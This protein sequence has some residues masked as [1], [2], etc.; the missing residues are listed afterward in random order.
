MKVVCARLSDITVI[1]LGALVSARL[2]FGESVPEPLLHA[3]FSALIMAIAVA[4]FPLFGI[5]R[6]WR[7]RAHVLLF[8]RVSLAWL[9]VQMI[10]AT[11][12]IALR[13]IHSLSL[14]WLSSWTCFTGLGLLGVRGVVYVVLARIRSAGAD[15]R[16]VAVVGSSPY[17]DQVLRDL[18]LHTSLGFRVVKVIELHGVDRP[19]S[20]RAERR[21]SRELEHLHAMAEAAELR[22]VWLALPLTA[23]EA[24]QRCVHTLRG[25]VVDLR[26]LPDVASLGIG[27]T[28]GVLDLM[29]RPAISLSPSSIPRDVINGKEVFDRLFAAAALL[30]LSPVLAG[31]ALAVKLS[32]PGP[33]FFRQKRK[34]LNGRA[35]TIYK[36]RTMRLHRTEHGVVR[37]ATRH[38]PRVT[39]LGR[40]LRRTSLDELPQF[41]NVLRGDMSV[42]G[43]RPHALEHDEF[44]RSLITGYMDRYRIKPGITGWAQINGHRGETDRLEKM[45]ARVDH[46]LYYL[47]NWSFWLDLRIVASTIWRGFVSERAY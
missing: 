5:Y 45:A 22:E 47:R 11:L 15:I 9:T 35:F 28:A 31:I 2:C 39:R 23:D 29:G 41:V 1:V 30:M 7:G 16:P 43:P 4:V 3:I 12:V 44:Y 34:G 13:G 40:F 10:G 6:S 17:I 24:L 14:Q 20:A 33:V 42:V 46:D 38:D 8:L 19:V 25:T 37:Q 27:A 32:S 18:A 26:Y 21:D 36:F